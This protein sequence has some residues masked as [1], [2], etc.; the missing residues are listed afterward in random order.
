MNH[1]RIEKHI[2]ISVSSIQIVKSPL[3]LKRP[4]TYYVTKTGVL[5]SLRKPQ[6]GNIRIGK[7]SL[8]DTPYI[9]ND[10]MLPTQDPLI[11]RCH[12]MINYQEFFQSA[13]S[14][15]MIS[16]LLGGHHRLGRNS[17]LLNLPQTL[18]KYI[19]DFLIERHF[20]ILIS[21]NSPTFMKISNLHP[22]TLSEGLLITIG[23]EVLL[24]I[25]DE[26]SQMCRICVNR[27]MENMM[28][29]HSLEKN[30]FLLGRQELRGMGV[31]ESKISRIQCRIWYDGNEWKIADGSREKSTVN[32][33]WVI[34]GKK[35]QELRNSTEIR[36]AECIL[37]VE[38]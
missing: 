20:P 17:I 34:V 37:K 5:Q 9:Y 30:E 29:F 36:I 21:P 28:V 19:L 13:L 3:Q 32:G 16:F 18:F 38:W 27:D 24:Q 2:K 31:D 11:A 1:E 10:I 35:F 14:D 15:S 26:D 4:Q 33:T 7:E 12:C 8:S 25:V 23:M 6:D 22:F